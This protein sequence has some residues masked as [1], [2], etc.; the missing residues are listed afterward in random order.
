MYRLMECPPALTNRVWNTNLL[1]LTELKR[2]RDIEARYRNVSTNN[3]PPDT[4]FKEAVVRYTV[5]PE[6]MLKRYPDLPV[7]KID[8]LVFEGNKNGVREELWLESN[9]S[10]YLRHTEK[11]GD[12]FVCLFVYETLTAYWEIKNNKLDGLY[13]LLG[14]PTKQEPYERDVVWRLMRFKDGKMVGTWIDWNIDSKIQAKIK[15][16]SDFEMP[17]LLEKLTNHRWVSEDYTKKEVK[18]P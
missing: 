9:Y 5:I 10:F 16:T 18:R 15:I 13:L 4:K 11:N 1:S 7:P 2:L 14:S 12:G 6:I 3:P 8:V 17:E